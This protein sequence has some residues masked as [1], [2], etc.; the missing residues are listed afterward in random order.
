VSH[1]AVTVPRPRPA[2]TVTGVTAVTPVTRHGPG[3]RHYEPP[4]SDSLAV[5]RAG[6]G[7]GPGALVRRR[8]YTGS[9]GVCLPLQ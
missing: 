4:E 2:V 8:R 9:R 7:P 6:R 5:A 3:W 1:G